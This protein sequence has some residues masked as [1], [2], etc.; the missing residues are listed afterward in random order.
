MIRCL[1]LMIL[2]FHNDQCNRIPVLLE[3]TSGSIIPQ[4]HYLFASTVI[5]LL[6]PWQM[7][8][9]CAKPKEIHLILIFAT[10][11]GHF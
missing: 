1:N 5:Q 6:L 2:L 7:S 10:G 11:Y 8:P 4:I 9:S 3:N